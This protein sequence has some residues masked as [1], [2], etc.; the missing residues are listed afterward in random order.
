VPA[1]SSGDPLGEGGGLAEVPTAICPGGEEGVSGS[2]SMEACRCPGSL[3]MGIVEVAH[4]NRGALVRIGRGWRN[5][6][7]AIT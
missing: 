3:P 2:R 7:E 5:H 4:G 1:V 6:M